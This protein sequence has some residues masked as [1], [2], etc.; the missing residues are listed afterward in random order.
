MVISY[1]VTRENFR[2]TKR[3][4]AERFP[5]RRHPTRNTISRCIWRFQE[6]GSVLPQH[7]TRVD[8]LVYR[9]VNVDED[10]LHAF[11]ENPRN[12]VHRV[13]FTLGISKS[14]VHRILRENGLHPFHFQRVQ[15]LLE[16]DEI[17]RIYF[18]E[19]IFGYLLQFFLD[20]YSTLTYDNVLKKRRRISHT[21]SAKH[22]IS[23]LYF[24]DGRGY[25]YTEWCI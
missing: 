1:G 15:Q 10:V 16:R 25:I 18:C 20:I 12:S 14:V 2:A 3:L 4:Y 13:A 17:P 7:P 23:R 24:V 22:F 11:E 19:G 21:V 6:T 5:N 9:Q 8:A